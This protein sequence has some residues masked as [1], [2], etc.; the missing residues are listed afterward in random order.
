MINV[1]V[2]GETGAGKEVLAQA[3]HRASPRAQ[4]PCLAVNCVALSESLLEAELFGHEKG[5]FTG[6]VQAREGLFEAAEGGTLFLDEV[7]ELPAS[8]QVKLLRV[9]EER[10]VLRVGSRAPRAVDVRF[11]S[12]T[13][14]DLWAEVQGGSFRADLFFRLNGM[15]LTV[16]PLRARPGDI[17]DL[18]AQFAARAAL[19]AG[20]PDVPRISPEARDLLLRHPWPGNVR[21]LR[22]A[23]EHAVVLCSGPVLMPEHL[24]PRL[25]SASPPPSRGTLREHVDAAEQERVLL[26]LER[27]QGNQT[28]A[29]AEL[30]IS[31]RTLVT[32]LTEWGL[33]NRRRRPT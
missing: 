9:L 18:A 21:E 5:A 15:A 31:R 17:E 8:I 12:A 14:R 1:L 29:A 7:G 16:P 13:N 30:G 32:R 25:L 6:A 11:V 27:C 24:P 4:K 3:I 23:I 10:K 19:E 28:L 22:N 2:L 33:T 20:R 26:V